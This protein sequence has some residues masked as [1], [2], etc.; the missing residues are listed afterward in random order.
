MSGEGTAELV[1][2]AVEGAVDYFCGRPRN[3]NPYDRTCARE[4]FEAWA[5]GWDDAAHL[6]EVRGKEEARRWLD[7]AA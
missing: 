5:I 1:P 2:I 7:V 6:L 4:W 3:Q